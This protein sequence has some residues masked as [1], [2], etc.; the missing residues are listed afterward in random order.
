MAST[1]VFPD[2][3]RLAIRDDIPGPE[4]ERAA[5]WARVQSANIARGFTLKESDQ[6]GFA[7][8]AEVNVDAPRIWAVFRDLCEALLGPVATLLIGEI[9]EEPTAL[10]PAGTPRLLSL[11]E[12]H[13][14]Q[15]AHD[16]FIQ[17]GLAEVRKN[18]LTEVFVTQTKHFNVW[19]NDEGFFRAILQRH[20]ISEA[21]KLEFLD[22]YPRTTTR[23]PEDKVLCLHGQFVEHFRKEI[24]SLS[25]S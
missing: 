11:L 20:G 15:L 7:L 22:E 17:F 6:T 8:Y 3:I 24:G 21:D 23:L 18:L 25:S 12:K 19:L 2:G 16:G 13:Q 5:S 1:L 14:Y 9:D 4:L 10:G